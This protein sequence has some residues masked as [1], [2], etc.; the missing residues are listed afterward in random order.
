MSLQLVRL[1]KFPAATITTKHDKT[2]RDTEGNNQ[3]ISLLLAPVVIAAELGY[4][5]PLMATW[6][7]SFWLDHVAPT[8]QVQPLSW[9][10]GFTILKFKYI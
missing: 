1:A 5:E 4:G 7:P 10:T 6:P 3:L 8:L 2:T 9:F